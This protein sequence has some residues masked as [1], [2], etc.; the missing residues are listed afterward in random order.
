MCVGLGDQAVEAGNRLTLNL[1]VAQLGKL[2]ILAVDECIETDFDVVGDALNL[3]E[4]TLCL[5]LQPRLK[6]VLVEELFDDLAIGRRK[7]A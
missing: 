7:A 5:A 1:P 6:C 3:R 2:P 4:A